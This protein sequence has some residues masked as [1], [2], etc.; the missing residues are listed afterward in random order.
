V[1]T[2]PTGAAILKIQ[3]PATKSGVTGIAQETAEKSS[4]IGI[5]AHLNPRRVFVL[6]CG[7]RPH[8]VHT[9]RFQNPPGRIGI[10]K[11]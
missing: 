8:T 7:S 4:K 3:L 11:M 9:Q 6:A 1:R 5:P 10:Q 2:A